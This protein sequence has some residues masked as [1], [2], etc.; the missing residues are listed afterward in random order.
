MCI[1]EIRKLEIVTI[2]D[3]RKSPIGDNDN[4]PISHSDVYFMWA[5]TGSSQDSKAEFS[6]KDFKYFEQLES[7]TDGGQLTKD[8]HLLFTDNS[9]L[10]AY[11]SKASRKLFKA[12]FSG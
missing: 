5:I 4:N 1:T 12:E 3:R 9:S 8:E 11:R 6:R 7:S 2:A 10:A